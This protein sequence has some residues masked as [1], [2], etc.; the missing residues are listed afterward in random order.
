MC[1][2]TNVIK[3]RDLCE[4]CKFT[5]APD[6]RRLIGQVCTGC[7]NADDGKCRCNSINHNTPCPHFKEYTTVK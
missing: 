3:S 4:Q 1:T 5:H 2:R 6:C 7:E